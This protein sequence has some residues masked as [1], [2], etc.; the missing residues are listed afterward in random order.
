MTGAA[1]FRPFFVAV[2]KKGLAPTGG[3]RNPQD[4]SHACKSGRAEKKKQ[5][6]LPRHSER[7]ETETLNPCRGTGFPLSRE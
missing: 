6:P 2:D 7:G 4:A 1:F 3:G 5:P